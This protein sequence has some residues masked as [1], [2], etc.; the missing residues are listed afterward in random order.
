ML[1]QTENSGLQACRFLPYGAMSQV[2]GSPGVDIHHAPSFNGVDDRTAEFLRDSRTAE[3]PSQTSS[4]DCHRRFGLG[5]P[6]HHNGPLTGTVVDTL[7]QP[8]PDKGL[9]V[10]ALISR[11]LQ[12]EAQGAFVRTVF[13]G[14]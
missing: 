5:S 1:I 3:T 11:L 4:P 2:V 12:L 9:S 14:E 6:V 8:V 10:P 7:F 13:V